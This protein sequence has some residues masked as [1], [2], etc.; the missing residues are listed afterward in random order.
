MQN[1]SLMFPNKRRP[2]FLWPWGE[3]WGIL[4]AQ[5]FRLQQSLWRAL[6]DLSNPSFFPASLFTVNNSLRPNR[7][8]FVSVRMLKKTKQNTTKKI[9][10]NMMF[11]DSHIALGQRVLI[12]WADQHDSFTSSSITRKPEQEKVGHFLSIYITIF[13]FPLSSKLQNKTH[14]DPCKSLLNKVCVNPNLEVIRWR[15]GLLFVAWPCS[16]SHISSLVWA[17]PPHSLDFYLVSK[18]N[19]IQFKILWI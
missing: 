7:T 17:M 10:K 2:Y 11:G 14:K 9:K 8:V 4:C 6:W 1:S 19:Q 5:C 15:L 3:E 16:C 13:W 12:L 18:C